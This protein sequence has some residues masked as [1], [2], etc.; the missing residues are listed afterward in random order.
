MDGQRFD[1]FAR[2]MATTSR[3]RLLAG[4]AGGLITLAVGRPAAAKN[5]T[6]GADCPKNHVCG[7]NGTCV[8]A[9][10]C[11]LGQ[12]PTCGACE[13]RGCDVVTGQWWCKSRCGKCQT[14]QGSACVDKTCGKCESC[15]ATSGACVSTCST[16]QVCCNGNCTTNTCG[17][18]CTRFDSSVCACIS[19]CP[20]SRACCGGDCLDTAFDTQNCGSCGHVC[21]PGQTCDFGECSCPGYLLPCPPTGEC[22]DTNTDSTHCG[23]SCVACPTGQSCCGGKC[24]DTN[25]DEN[26]CGGCAGSGGSV[27]SDPMNSVCSGGQCGCPSNTS[28]NY[29]GSS[30]CCSDIVTYP[31]GDPWQCCCNGRITWPST[32]QETCNPCGIGTTFCYCNDG[33]GGWGCCRDGEVCAGC[34]GGP[35]SGGPIC[36]A[37]TSG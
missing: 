9:H 15:N 33:I 27:C 32:G 19:T 30:W 10:L 4:L 29:N 34:S 7:P 3:R 24:V 11:D 6:T 37:P 36:A 8:K 1:A 2:V 21:P 12:A 13:D 5:C 18:P 23:A 25:T 17:T 26:N 20:P 31:N 14:C 28:C 22:F 35:G 16:G